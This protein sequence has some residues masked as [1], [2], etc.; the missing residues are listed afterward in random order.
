MALGEWGEAV[1]VAWLLRNRYRVIRRNYR[2][3]RGGEV[4]VVARHKPTSTLC[5]IE[6]KTRKSDRYG[7]PALAVDREKEALIVR[8][9][10]SWLRLLDM[11][12]VAFRFDII[13]V[14]ASEPPEIS[15]IEDAFH[16]PPDIFY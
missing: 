6:V 2:A 7:R 8:G 1:A 11:P 5:F 16:L 15:M 12:D 13:E 14:I 9:A 4:D 10:M 3:N